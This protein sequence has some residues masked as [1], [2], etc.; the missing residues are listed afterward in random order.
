MGILK[1]MTSALSL[2]GPGRS[3]ACLL[4]LVAPRRGYRVVRGIAYAAGARHSMD[5]YIPEALQAPAPV[6]LFFYGG[7]FQAGRKSEYRLVGGTLAR[8]GLIVAVADYRIHPQARFPDFLEDGAQAFVALKSVVAQHGGDAG[9]IFLAGHSAG[10]YMAVMLAAN[11]AYLNAVGTDPSAIRGVIAIA[12]NCRLEALT[13]PTLIA[14]FGGAHRPETQ[15]VSFIDGIKPPM[16]VAVGA[17][18]GRIQ[19]ECAQALC[20]RLR[21][22]GSEVEERIYPRAGHMGIVLG[23][24]FPSLAPLGDDILG[25][26]RAH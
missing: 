11:P 19:R 6:V 4:N 1:L 2:F 8:A 14:I 15:A 10:A 23:F 26:V 16:L 18:D 17:K 13:D 24:A 12:G 22:A 5:L 9:R 20:T 21:A 25:F 3:P 7:G